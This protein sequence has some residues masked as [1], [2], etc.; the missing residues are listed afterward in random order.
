MKITHGSGNVFIDLGFSEPEA[1][2]LTLKAKLFHCLQD[3]IR[4]SKLTQLQTAEKL[5][6]DQPKVSNI[7]QGKMSGF[8]IERITNYLLKLGYDLRIEARPSVVK[9]GSARQENSRQ[10]VAG[11]KVEAG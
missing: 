1:A 4:Q 3:A 7:L 6:I 8:S 9:V 10:K 11:R 2:E 5:G